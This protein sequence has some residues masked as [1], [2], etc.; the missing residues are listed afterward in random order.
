MKKM[1]PTLIV[2]QVRYVRKGI[3]D[4][5]LQVRIVLQAVEG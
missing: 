2:E 4:L 3:V 5:T 1:N